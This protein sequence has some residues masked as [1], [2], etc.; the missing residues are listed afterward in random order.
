MSVERTGAGDLAGD[1]PAPQDAVGLETL[2]VMQEAW[3]YNAWQYRR[4]APYVASR[5]CEI[6]SGIGSMSELLLSTP[7]ERVV[8]TDRDAGY[9]RTLRQRFAARPPV[10]VEWLDLPDPDAADRFQAYRLDTVV[11]LNVI[12]HIE[13]DME[14]MRTIRAMLQ[15][16]GRFVMLVPALPALHGTLDQELGHFRRYTRSVLDARLAQAGFQ[17]ERIFYFN[18]VGAFGWWFNARV[19]RRPQIAAAQV[20]WFDAFVPF[21]RFEDLFRLPFGQSVISVAVKV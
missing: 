5:V 19:L 14:A 1:G 3:R 9:L 20:R 16:G 7:R 18:L 12:E 10:A 11:A 21:L 2:R 6:G 4:I 15:P 13:D 8:L 17:A